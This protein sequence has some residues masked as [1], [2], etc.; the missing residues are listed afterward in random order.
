MKTELQY[1]GAYNLLECKLTTSGGVVVD[2]AKGNQ[3]L[4]IN[5]EEDI[6]SNSV[7]GNIVIGDTHNLIT[8]MPIIGQE[9]LSLKLQTPNFTEEKSSLNFTGGKELY[10][11]MIGI[12]TELSQGAQIYELR[13]LSQEFI[14]NN[15]VKV[16][17]SYTKS[18]SDIVEDVMTSKKYLGTSKDLFIEPTVGVRKLVVPNIHPFSLIKNIVK[19]SVSSSNSPHYLFYEDSDGFHFKTVQELYKQ[20]AVGIFHYSENLPKT[21]K[22]KEQVVVDLTKILKYELQATNDMLMNTVSGMLGS[23]S[24]SHDVYSKNYVKKTYDYFKEFDNNTRV[25]NSSNPKYSES[26]D[27]NG[28]TLGNYPDSRTYVH[29]IS[30]KG[31]IDANHMK[32]TPSKL[33]DYHSEYHSRTVELNTGI[34][35]TLQIPGN[36]ALRV[37]NV[38]ELDIPVIGVDHNDERVDRFFSGNFLIKNLRHQF[39]ESTRTHIIHM[40]V[41]KD[42]V[43]SSIPTAESLALY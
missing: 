11:Y 22:E 26:T 42:S 25:S 30:T 19:E 7:S 27:L 37:G 10:V 21:N 2:L 36:T 5:F 1:A 41:V 40:A 20:P 28:K 9:L 16:S 34:V 39:M 12:R 32:H 15:R 29:P 18:L 13:F 3:I 33:K 35:L 8:E 43:E 17:K 4:E 38:I 14:M 24:I 31:T 6:Y 23:T